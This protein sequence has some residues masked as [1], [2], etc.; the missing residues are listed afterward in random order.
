MIMSDLTKSA[1]EGEGEGDDDDFGDT[2]SLLEGRVPG[3]QNGRKPKSGGMYVHCS[4]YI[5]IGQVTQFE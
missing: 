1:S 5:I 3:T 4:S 2:I